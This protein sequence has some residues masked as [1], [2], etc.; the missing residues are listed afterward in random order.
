[1]FWAWNWEHDSIGSP[2]NDIDVE[3]CLLAGTRSSI[4]ASVW[5]LWHHVANDDAES[6][7]EMLHKCMSCS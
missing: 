1:M 3:I 6:V 5:F 2:S 7:N 4:C